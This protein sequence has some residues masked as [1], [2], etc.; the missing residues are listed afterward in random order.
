MRVALGASG[1][2]VIRQ[3][4][5]EGARLA[6]MGTVAGMLGSVLVARA[7]ARVTPGG[8]PLT[9]WVGL[10]APLVLIGA[11]AVASVLPARRAVRIDPIAIIR[12][13]SK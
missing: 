3:V 9:V 1:W 6:G 4:V 10:V 12:M 7:L 11:V 13:D 8:D 5:M 2:R